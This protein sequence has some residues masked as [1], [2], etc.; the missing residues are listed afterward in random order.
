MASIGHSLVG[1]TVYGG[2]QSSFEHRHKSY[3][4]GQC[5]FASRLT[6]THPRTREAMTFSAPLPENFEKLLEILRST[7]E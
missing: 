6:L 7:V 3:I 5:L 4:S 2:G 1:D